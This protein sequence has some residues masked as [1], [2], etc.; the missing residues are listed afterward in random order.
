MR[1]SRLKFRYKNYIL[2]FAFYNFNHFCYNKIMKREKIL[3]ICKGNSGR[4][5]MAEAFFNYLSKTKNAI[6][7]GIK[8]DKRIHPWT[9]RVMKEAGID[10]SRR[11]PKLLTNRK[12]EK[13][14]KIIVMESEVLKNIPSEY[15]SKLERWR[16]GKLLGKSP[17]KVRV[18]RNQIKK[19]VERL[20][21]AI[22]ETNQ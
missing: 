12:M 19:R 8:P 7:A 17:K 2:I 11:K 3:F 20:I 5:Q 21:K 18:I 14:D 10:V 15:S 9:V 22:D 16:I 1:G 13:A 6:S 4:S